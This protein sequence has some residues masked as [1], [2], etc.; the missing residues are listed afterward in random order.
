MELTETLRC[1]GRTPRVRRSDIKPGLTGLAD[2]RSTGFPKCILIRV[3][4]KRLA[5]KLNP[6]RD[7]APIRYS[8]EG[9]YATWQVMLVISGRLWRHSLHT[10]SSVSYEHSFTKRCY[11]LAFRRPVRAC[12]AYSFFPRLASRFSDII[13]ATACL[14]LLTTGPLFEPLCNSPALNLCMTLVQGKLHL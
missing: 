1:T 5:G 10:R 11:G 13:I 4:S 9:A 2:T 14:R 3:E 7:R 8:A 6:F 12:D